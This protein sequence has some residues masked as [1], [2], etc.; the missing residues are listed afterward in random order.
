MI[1]LAII[2]TAITI[3]KISELILQEE[4]TTNEM[5]TPEQIAESIIKKVSEVSGVPVHVIKSKTRKREIVV[6]RQVAQYLI[7]KRLYGIMKLDDMS[8]LFNQTHAT[9]YNSYDSVING[10]NTNDRFVMPLIE[11]FESKEESKSAA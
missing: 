2:C 10:I 1:Y 5:K 9:L 3:Y 4:K 7:Y 6:P 8:A 11:S